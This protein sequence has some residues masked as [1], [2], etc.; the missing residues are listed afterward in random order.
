MAPDSWLF[1]CR[2]HNCPALTGIAGCGLM[3]M[4]HSVPKCDHQPPQTH[5]QTPT[6]GVH[7]YDYCA[8]RYWIQLRFPTAIIQWPTGVWHFMPS[9]L[10]PEHQLIPCKHL[11]WESLCRK[12]SQLCL[13]VPIKG[14]VW[15]WGC[16]SIRYNISS[17]LTTVGQWK[18]PRELN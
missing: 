2:L 7:K 18:N 13:D 1:R 5:T 8:E 16:Y 10:R 3:C 15:L 11:K 14:Y 9:L 6:I 4:H 17:R 12:F